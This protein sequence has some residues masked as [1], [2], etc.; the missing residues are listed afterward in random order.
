MPA[1]HA[2]LLPPPPHVQRRPHALA[3]GDRAG[4]ALQRLHYAVIPRVR[5]GP[6]ARALWEQHPRSA[7]PPA[8]P[9]GAVEHRAATGRGRPAFFPR[10]PDP[11]DA[12]A[13]IARL[14]PWLR[15]RALPVPA[16]A[17]RAFLPARRRVRR[18]VAETRQPAR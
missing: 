5:G 8:A 7:L 1:G 2:L 15:H 17:N 10:V 13:A 3:R 6:A 4:H 18:A 12:A 9:P 16:T 14:L 11:A